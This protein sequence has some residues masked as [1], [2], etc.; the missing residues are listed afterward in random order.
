MRITEFIDLIAAEYDNKLKTP[1]QIDTFT[2]NCHGLLKKY[3]G[4]ILGF[5][6]YEFVA[7]NLSRTSPTVGK[8]IKL[9]E[10]KQSEEH[11]KKVPIEKEDWQIKK[12]FAEEF[13]KTDKFKW[14]ALNMIGYDCVLFAEKEGREPNQAEVKHMLKAHKLFAENLEQYEADFGTVGNSKRLTD[15]EEAKLLEA[16]ITPESNEEKQPIRASL[17]KGA[18]ALNQRNL[19][20]HNQF[21]NQ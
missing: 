18:K 12:Q 4:E 2:K 14:A 20:Y 11:K 13:Q 7:Q 3:E 16:G 8:I 5:A 17:Y 1:A 9:C 15:E 19:D 21:I 10:S 6:Y